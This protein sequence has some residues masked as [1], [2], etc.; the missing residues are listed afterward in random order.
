MTWLHHGDFSASIFQYLSCRELFQQIT[1]IVS[2]Q[3]INKSFYFGFRHQHSPIDVDGLEV[4]L[5]AIGVKHVMPVLG[6]SMVA[7]LGLSSWC[8]GLFS[9]L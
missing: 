9:M 7:L 8:S 6:I 5:D 2:D 4:A 3:F 1:L